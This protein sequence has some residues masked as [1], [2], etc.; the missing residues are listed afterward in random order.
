MCQK[1]LLS[2]LMLSETAG[3]RVEA[4]PPVVL[5]IRH[6]EEAWSCREWVAQKV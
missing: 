6:A 1:V 2:L 5:S 4:V 3:T